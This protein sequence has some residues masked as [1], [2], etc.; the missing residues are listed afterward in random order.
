MLS[1]SCCSLF[2]SLRELLFVVFLIL[3]LMDLLVFSSW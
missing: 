1:S 3:L 2:H